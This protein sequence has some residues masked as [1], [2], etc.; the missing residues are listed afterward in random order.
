MSSWTVLI[1]EPARGMRTGHCPKTYQLGPLRSA[2]SACFRDFLRLITDSGPYSHPPGPL[3]AP[4][5]VS[6]GHPIMSGRFSLNAGSCLARSP[7]RALMSRGF[8]GNARLY[9]AGSAPTRAQRVAGSFWTRA[10][11]CRVLPAAAATSR[12]VARLPVGPEVRGV[13]TRKSRR[14]RYLCW[15][16]NVGGPNHVLVGAST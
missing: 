12:M 3:C 10:Q 15:L 11:V 14:P 5:P 9:P 1:L 13:I 8:S 16:L 2:N 4:G 7:Q 6:P